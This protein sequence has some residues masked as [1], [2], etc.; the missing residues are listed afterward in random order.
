MKRLVAAAFFLAQT[1]MPAVATDISEAY[2]YIRRLPNAPR[3]EGLV[4]SYV[5]FT[6]DRYQRCLLRLDSKRT[7]DGIR[8]LSVSSKK[9]AKGDEHL[10]MLLDTDCNRGDNR[11]FTHFKRAD[12]DQH[13]VGRR[14]FVQ[15]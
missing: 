10:F 13:P 7:R 12:Q 9:D 1:A 3:C 4:F 14:G 15:Y 6:S 11:H 8:W 2:T 5:L